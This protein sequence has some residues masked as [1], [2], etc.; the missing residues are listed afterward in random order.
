MTVILEIFI[1]SSG[2]NR[3]ENYDRNKSQQKIRI[4]TGKDSRYH[5]GRIHVGIGIAYSSCEKPAN[6][7]TQQQRDDKENKKVNVNGR[8][9]EPLL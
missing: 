5:T 8:P 7:R 4:E 6:S 2:D 1:N 3:N 9:L